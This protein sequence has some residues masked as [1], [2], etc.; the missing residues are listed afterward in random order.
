MG[1]TELSRRLGA[2]LLPAGVWACWFAVYVGACMITWIA[3]LVVAAGGA[4]LQVPA[5]HLLALRLSGAVTPTPDVAHVLALVAHNVPVCC[6]PLLL[7][8]VG[9]HRNRVARRVADVL[10]AGGV[11][12]NVLQVGVAFGAYGQPLLAFVPQLPLEWAALA[13]GATG[14]LKH[15]CRP[16][17]VRHGISLVGLTGLLLVCAAVI[18]TFGVPHCAYLTGG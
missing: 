9:A 3:A 8:V 14:W 18:E 16:L 12:V 1:A 10:V 17:T 11:I 6:W 13:L 15:R 7:G 2:R 4:A 5:R